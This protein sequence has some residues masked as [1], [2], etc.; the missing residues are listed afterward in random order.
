MKKG[1][2]KLYRQIQD[3]KWWRKQRFSWAL[4]WIDLLLKASHQDTGIILNNKEYKVP[5]GS[6]ITSQRKLAKEWRWAI[7]TVNCFLSFLQKTEHS[8]SY[9]TEHSFTHIFILNWDKFQ[10]NPNTKNNPSP[11]SS[12]TVAEQLPKQNKNVKNV[13]EEREFSLSWNSFSSF[14]IR[15]IKEE[16]GFEPSLNAKDRNSYFNFL[17][18]YEE[19]EARELVEYYLESNFGRKFRSLATILQPFVINAWLAEKKSKDDDY[20]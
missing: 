4:A 8:I 16:K 18:T 11:N 17:A 1:Y 7:A 14:F 19:K 6:F 3:K 5:A 10:G 9:K 12:R 20:E 2:I 15:R 13:K